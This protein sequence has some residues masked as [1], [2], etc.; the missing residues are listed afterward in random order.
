MIEFNEFYIKTIQIYN[1][2]Q[3]KMKKQ[4]KKKVYKRKN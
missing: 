2:N 3:T 4:N 1:K